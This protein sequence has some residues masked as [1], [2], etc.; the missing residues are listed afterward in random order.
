VIGGRVL[1]IGRPAGVRRERCP[2]EG[3]TAGA[4]VPSE[5]SYRRSGRTAGA[6]VPS[7]K[8][9]MRAS[10]GTFPGWSKRDRILIQKLK[11]DSLSKH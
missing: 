4:V 3:R 10:P 2:S 7:G 1:F 9:K 11:W 8:E 5:R 6:V